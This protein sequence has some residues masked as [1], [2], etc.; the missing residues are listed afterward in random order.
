MS[1]LLKIDVML[2]EAICMAREIRE[3][4]DEERMESFLHTLV[5]DHPEFAL[6]GLAY[7]LGMMLIER[8]DCELDELDD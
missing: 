5:H 4:T 6:I 3:N 2:D 7:H 1:D 8:N